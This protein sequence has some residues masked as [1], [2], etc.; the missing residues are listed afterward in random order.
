MSHLDG[1]D[2]RQSGL[3]L[4]VGSTAVEKERGEQGGIECRRGMATPE[5]VAYSLGHRPLVGETAHRIVAG[6]A[7][8]RGVG[9]QAHVEVELAAEAIRAGVI[10]L[11]VGIDAAHTSGSSLGGVLVASVPASSLSRA[12]SWISIAVAPWGA[13]AGLPGAARAMSVQPAA[14]PLK[15]SGAVNFEQCETV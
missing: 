10:S 8:Y 12:A 9:R 11:P 6:R 4:E 5:L 13:R 3:L 1:I 7:R 2:D 15:S 14:V